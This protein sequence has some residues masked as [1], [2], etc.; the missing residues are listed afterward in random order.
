ML[1][2]GVL[3]VAAGMIGGLVLSTTLPSGGPR[4]ASSQDDKS[5]RLEVPRGL[6]ET[7]GS[8]AGLITSPFVEVAKKVIPA[9]VSVETRHTMSHPPVEGPQEDL[10]KQL[11]PD[12][13]D[14]GKIEVPSSGSGFLIDP[15]GIVLTND[16]VVTGTETQT[17]HLSDGRTYEAWLV[18]TD[19]GTDVA[20]LKLDVSPGDPPLPVVPL[21]DSDEMQVGDWAMAIG[22]PLGEL[23]GTVTVGIISAKGRKDLIIAGGGPAY[24][25]YIQTDASIN[26]GNSGGPLVNSRGEVIGINSAINP[27]GQGIGFAIPVNMVRKVATQ[28]I[29]NGTIHRGYLGIYPQEI[30]SDIKEAWG[31]KNPQGVLVG[32]VEKGTPAA[33]AGLQVGDIILAFNSKSVEDVSDFRSLVAEAG[34]GVGVPIHLIRDGKPEDLRVVL[35][36]RPGTPAPPAHHPHHAESGPFGATLTDISGKLKDDYEL[37]VESGVVI[38]EVHGSSP[39]RRGGLRVGDV[40][41]EINRSRIKDAREATDLVSR[42]QEQEKPLVFLVQRGTTT[43][44]LSVHLQDSAP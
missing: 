12:S 6:L 37:Q 43:T 3:L 8:R 44:Y 26:F 29:Q 22:N 5:D 21:G 19:P 25:D 42:A 14:D 32:S 33:E 31:L 11:F 38:T 13:S 30:T 34:V 7:P 35:A 4:S 41:L 2:T 20:V 28:L 40:V 17:V 9:V 1:L 36:E 39:A 18:G 24:Q 27:N 23:E 15:A 10:F 16:H